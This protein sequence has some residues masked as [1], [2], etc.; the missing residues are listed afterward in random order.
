[1]LHA[2]FVSALAVS[3]ISGSSDFG[4]YTAFLSSSPDNSRHE[5]RDGLD[6]VCE[7]V[8]DA[9]RTREDEVSCAW[10]GAKTP[11]ILVGKPLGSFRAR[12]T[13]NPLIPC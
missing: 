7:N 10:A 8:E 4:A 1:M 12:R 6:E 9:P 3:Y 11:A 5:N 13:P 2:G